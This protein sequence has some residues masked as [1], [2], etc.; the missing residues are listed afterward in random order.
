MVSNV[1]QKEPIL[2]LNG[3]GYEKVNWL[4]I[5]LTLL[6]MYDDGFCS[7]CYTTNLL[8]DGCLSSI[9]SSYDENAKMGTSVM[10]PEHCDVLHMCSCKEQV[11]FQAGEAIF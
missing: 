1:F 11:N 5:Q 10:N 3:T 7:L 9:S 4:F 6:V 8:K 2:H